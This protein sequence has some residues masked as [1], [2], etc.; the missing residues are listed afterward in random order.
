MFQ[1]WVSHSPHLVLHTVA[2]R[3]DFCEN[4]EAPQVSVDFVHAPPLIFDFSFS[5]KSLVVLDCRAKSTPTS[6]AESTFQSCACD[7][8]FLVLKQKEFPQQSLPS[9]VSVVFGRP[10]ELDS[11]HLQRRCKSSRTVRNEM[12][13]DMYFE[14]F[15]FC[16]RKCMK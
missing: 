5:T 8:R 7:F 2:F 4:H 11:L 9:F 12:T 6:F 15:M 13:G 1:M 3:F 16:G 14:L 10:D